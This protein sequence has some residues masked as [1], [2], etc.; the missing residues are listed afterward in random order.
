MTSDLDI[1]RT[2]NALI[3][4]HGDEAD[5]VAAEQADSFL[6]AGYIDAGPLAHHQTPPCNAR[7]VHT[8]ES[9]ADENPVPR[10]RLLLGVKQSSKVRFQ[11]W[12]N[13]L[14]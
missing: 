1:F 7:S 12:E 5:L 8:F 2:A 11:S 14:I 13:H 10:L 4:E 3:R 6:D 9:G